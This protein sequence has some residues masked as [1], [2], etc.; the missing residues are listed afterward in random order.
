MILLDTHVLVWMHL[1]DARLGRRARQLV[2]RAWADGEAGA[3]AITFWEIG[4]LQAKGRVGV[5]TDVLTWRHGLVAAGLVEVPV[6]GAIAAQA[7]VLAG[8]HGDPADRI[9]AATALTVPGGRLL[10]AD[11]RLLEWP[12]QLDRVDASA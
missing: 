3:S 11:R 6:T 4:M 7:G 2:D 5:M 1:D 10:T 8:M 12:G 9:I